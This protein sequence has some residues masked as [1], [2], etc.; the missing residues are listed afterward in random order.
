[1]G[2][3]SLHSVDLVF[4]VSLSILLHVRYS[5]EDHYHESN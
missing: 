3:F 4:L 1:M 2:S 5:I